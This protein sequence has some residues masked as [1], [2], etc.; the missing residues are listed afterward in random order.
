MKILYRGEDMAQGIVEHA[1][2]MDIQQIKD[3]EN[4]TYHVKNTYKSEHF[5]AHNGTFLFENGQTIQCSTTEVGYGVRTWFE[6]PSCFR[7][8]KRM[9]QAKRS[10]L[11]KCRECHKLVYVKSRLSGNQF[12]YV[13]RQIRELQ[14]ELKVSR[15]NYWPCFPNCIVDADI[16]WLPII[17]PKYMRQSTFDELRL[18]LEFLIAERV[19][20][21]LAMVG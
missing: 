6:C 2:Y 17:K 3:L 4:G 10:D 20:L 21:W 8:T 5:K 19:R 7:N 13:T 14:H 15:D 12:E 16:E 9:Y 1:V 11:W 18:K